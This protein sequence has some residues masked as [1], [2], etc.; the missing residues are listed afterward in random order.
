MEIIILKHHDGSFT[1]S[2]N[3]VSKTYKG[4][5]KHAKNDFKRYLNYLLQ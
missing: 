2:S 5:V 1:L 3:G 4:S